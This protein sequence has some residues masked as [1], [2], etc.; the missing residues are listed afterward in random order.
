MPVSTLPSLSLCHHPSARRRLSVRRL[1]VRR[2]RSPSHRLV[3]PGGLQGHLCP[4]VLRPR[5]V[6]CQQP[7]NQTPPPSASQRPAP[8]FQPCSP[9]TE[10]FWSDRAPQSTQ[11]PRQPLSRCPTFLAA[12]PPVRTGAAAPLAVVTPR[13]G[14]VPVPIRR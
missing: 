12:A 9:V 1:S 14:Q 11:S 2:H 8:S 7:C 4:L 13:H 3:I 10:A 6:T 5:P